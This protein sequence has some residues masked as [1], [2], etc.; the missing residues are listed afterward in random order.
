MYEIVFGNHR[1]EAYRRLGKK[2]IPAIITSMTDDEVFLAQLTENLVRNT[3]VN[4]IEEAKGYRM[5]VRRG[6]TIHAIG[7][8]VGKCDSY[9]SERLSLLDRLDHRL[10]SKVSHRNKYLTPSHAELLARVRDHN[11][12]IKIAEMVERKRL[13]VRSLEAILENGALPGEA[14]V[15]KISGNWLIHIPNEFASVLHLS[16]GQSLH[17]QARRNKL[18]LEDPT[19]PTRGSRT[20]RNL[21]EQQS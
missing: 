19:R 18:I 13:S 3:Y 12:Q 9:I 17:I 15:E 2:E 21:S 14:R 6:W 8:K 1:F 10:L 11:K 16:T 5:L 20:T 7:C 4:P